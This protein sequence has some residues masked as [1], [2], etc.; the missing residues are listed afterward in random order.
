MDILQFWKKLNAIVK[1]RTP[2]DSARKMVESGEITKEEVSWALAALATLP[3]TMLE[4]L[5]DKE[6]YKRGIEQTL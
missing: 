3:I 6:K 5:S 4:T 2:M 1:T